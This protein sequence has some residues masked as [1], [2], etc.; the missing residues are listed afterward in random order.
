M[1]HDRFDD[2]KTSGLESDAYWMGIFLGILLSFA[3]TF[4]L[5]FFLVSGDILTDLLPF[6]FLAAIALSYLLSRLLI[7]AFSALVRRLRPT[8]QHER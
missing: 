3:V 1:W 4:V 6:F 5:A 8:R 7:R 2:S